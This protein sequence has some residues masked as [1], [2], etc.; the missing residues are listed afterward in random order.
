MVAKDVKEDKHFPLF[1]H[2]NPVRRLF[3]SNPKKYCQYV[4]HGHVVADLGCG[5]GYFTFSLAD[6]VGPKGT[7]YA[8]DSDPK[9]I[10]A[11]RKR[12]E[13]RGYK[14][15]QMFP[16]SATDLGFIKDGL[17][18]FVLADGLLCSM[19]PQH[20]DAATREIQRILKPDAVAYLKVAE[21]SWS[22][23]GLAEWQNLLEG[24]KII[25]KSDATH[26]GGRWAV[27]SKK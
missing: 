21:G 3:F 11:L 22:Y 27:V 16:S 18:D 20:Q 13:K 15:I 12:A 17:V 2:Y 4:S 25:Q 6:A 10:H 5:P 1:V 26:G 23:V 19:A 24:F 8:V 9:A 7:V 14:N